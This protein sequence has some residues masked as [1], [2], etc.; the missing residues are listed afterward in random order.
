[1]ELLLMLSIMEEIFS[2][3]IKQILICTGEKENSSHVVR[4]IRINGV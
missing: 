4:G 1:M 2:K 3:A